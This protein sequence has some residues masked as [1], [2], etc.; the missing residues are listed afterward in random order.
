[1]FGKGRSELAD[2]QGHEAIA[3][4]EECH[5]LELKVGSRCLPPLKQFVNG[6]LVVHVLRIVNLCIVREMTIVKRT[7]FGNEDPDER[8]FSR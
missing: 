8:G 3:S 1:M 5:W 2:G 4:S 6:V 7:N